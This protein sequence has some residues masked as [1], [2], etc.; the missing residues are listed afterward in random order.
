M[1]W[2]R[3]LLSAVLVGGCV[4]C[5]GLVQ[6]VHSE[7]AVDSQRSSSSRT[8]VVTSPPAGNEV[9]LQPARPHSSPRPPAGLPG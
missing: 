5:V 3:A 7:Q 4:W 8:V 9:A 1:N 6:Q 2:R